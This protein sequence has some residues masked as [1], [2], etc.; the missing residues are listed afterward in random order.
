ME[1]KS[2][3]FSKEDVM[4]MANSPAGKQLLAML[5]QGD[6]AKLEQVIAQ[7]KA[8]DFSSASQNL[9]AMLSSPEAQRLMKD[10]GGK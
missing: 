2:Q 8:G 4:R 3:D 10:L 6:S 5:R 9:Q 1:K 7:A